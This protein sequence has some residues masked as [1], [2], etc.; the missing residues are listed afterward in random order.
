MDNLFVEK[1]AELNRQKIE[2]EMAA[3]RLEEKA[4]KG[5]EKWLDKNLATLG[6]LM[7]AGGEKLRKRRAVSENNSTKLLRSAARE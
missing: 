2:E 1:I 5:Q 7:V 3:I 6:D 4:A